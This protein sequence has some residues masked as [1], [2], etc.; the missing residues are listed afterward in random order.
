MKNNTILFID[1]GVGG[2]STLNEV[3]KLTRANYIYF[4]D[5]KFAPYG[6]KSDAFLHSR[7]SEII[8]NH[9]ANFDISMVVLACNTATTTSI[10]FLRGIFPNLVIVGTEPAV[11]IAIDN[12]FKAP[13]IIATP[14]TIKHFKVQNYPSIKTIP[15][16]NLASTIEENLI[17]PSPIN[18]IKLKKI[19]CN[20]SSLTKNN[21]CIVLGCTH[22]PFIKHELYKLA[23]KP[24]F[25][26]NQGIARRIH[27]LFAQNQQKFSV[28]IEISSKK[29][30]ELRKYKKILKQILAKQI[31]LC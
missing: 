21:D 24:I 4:A 8:Q 26:G 22:Y 30:K 27:T 15:C 16:P 7:L 23:Q 29:P 13:A 10:N 5:T 25:D 20:L 11:K 12:K 19:L 9:L 6:N 31:K 17:N 28:K 2:L 18:S 1:S 3:I 14:Q